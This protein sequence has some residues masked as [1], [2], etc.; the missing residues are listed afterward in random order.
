MKTIVLGGTG[1]IGSYLI[2]MLV[3]EGHEVI[4]ITRSDSKPYI[5]S[6]AWNSVARI[7]MNRES[8]P[9]F[10][11]KLYDMNP[12]IIVDLINFKF[13][14]TKKIVETFKN[15]SLSHYIFC[16]SVWAHGKAEILPFNP[17]DLDKKPLDE[18]GKNKFQS[19]LFLKKQFNETN[20]PA[21]IIMPGQIS[22][23]GWNIISPLGN[24]NPEIFQNIADGEVTYLPNFGMETIHHVHAEDVAQ[25]FLN[26]II[27]RDNSLG[28]SFHAVSGSSITLYGYTEMVYKYFE[29]EPSIKYLPWEDWKKRIDNEEDSLSTYY[30]ISRS[31]Y[32]DIKKEE[33]LL[34]YKPKHTNI[35]TIKIAIKSYIER[36]I[37][38]LK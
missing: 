14:D 27:Y 5:E 21:T 2:P 30:H 13:D 9:D 38:T 36:G 34:K 10:E 3:N 23:P 19:E 24:A 26:A 25:V 7:L 15:S 11:K 12:D 29:K 28:E 31:G 37:I 16:S 4:S 35:D 33:K 20:F 32:F 6:S 1:H 22:G 8:D 18:Y 17:D